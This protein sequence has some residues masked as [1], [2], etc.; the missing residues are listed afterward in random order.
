MSLL[1]PALDPMNPDLKARGAA[2]EDCHKVIYQV[3]CD[4]SG[5]GTRLYRT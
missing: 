5:I 3:I 1:Q 4:L 2:L